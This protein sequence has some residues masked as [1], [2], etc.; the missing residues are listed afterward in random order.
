YKWKPFTSAQEMRYQQTVDENRKRLAQKKRQQDA[1]RLQQEKDSVKPFTS[2]DEMTKMQLVK[3][4]AWEHPLVTLPVG[5]VDAN[6]RRAAGSFDQPI[7]LGQQEQQSHEV[8]ACI[9]DVV[10]QVQVT[11]RH[12]QEFLGSYI[13]TAFKQGLTADDRDILS[14]LCPPVESKIKDGTSI[15]SKSTSS[16]RTDDDEEGDK[17]EDSGGDDIES[18]PSAADKSFLAFYTILMTRVYSRKKVLKT[19]AQ[20]QVD[21]LFSRAATLGIDLPPVACHTR[22]YS[23]TFL[24]ESTVNRIYKSMKTMYRNGSIA[25]EKEL[26]K[27]DNNGKE[28]SDTDDTGNKEEGDAGNKEENIPVEKKGDRSGDNKGD[29]ACSKTDNAANKQANDSNT[30]RPPR[31]DPC[32]PAIENYLVLNQACGRPRII[33]PL[34]PL[35]SRYVGFSE[36]QLLPLFW[37][38]PTLKE[39]IR[40]MM[41]EDRY[42]RNPTTVPSQQD[43]LDWLITIAPGRI[44]TA[45]VSDIGLPAGKNDRGFRKSTVVMDKEG[46]KEHLKVLR[47]E[48]FEPREWTGKGYIHKGTIQTNGRLLQILAFN[49]KEL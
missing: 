23:T 10:Q 25:L 13:E 40:N 24:L 38:W 18:E 46:L 9:Q 39:K 16:A 30:A 31:I 17:D 48:S 19:V 15:N 2:I 5:T 26:D 21:K 4:L 34:S 20:K 43:M 36:R 28:E 32:L 22:T 37:Q 6:C 14:F 35:S 29:G 27:K 41:V 1:Q 12:T 8:F 7:P 42:F 33:A 3:A 47:S 45:F 44:V 11:K 49:V